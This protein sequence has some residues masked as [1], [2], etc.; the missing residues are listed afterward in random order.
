M[1]RDTSTSLHRYSTIKTFFWHAFFGNCILLLL[2]LLLSG[3]ITG[4]Y[5]YRQ[6]Q[7]DLMS[8]NYNMLYQLQQT[9][10]TML[11]TMDNVS[12]Y[13]SSNKDITTKLKRA[14]TQPTLTLSSINDAQNAGNYLRNLIYTN[15]YIDNI[16]IYYNNNN[17]R[18]LSSTAGL[19]VPESSLPDHDWIA[20][21]KECSDRFWFE[22]KTL[23]ADSSVSSYQVIRYYKKLYS[24]LN[25]ESS[26][27]VIVVNCSIP[28][29]QDYVDSLTIS[30]HQE[31]WLVSNNNMVLFKN[32]NLFQNLAPEDILRSTSSDSFSYFIRDIDGVKCFVSV[33]PSERAEG[34]RTVSIV[35]CSDLTEST[36]NVVFIYAGVMLLSIVFAVFLSLW[37]ANNEISK[38]NRI[39]NIFTDPEHSEKQLKSTR[40][41]VYDPY[42]Y[43]SSNI[44]QLF[45]Q[46]NYL[47][48]R[49][50]EQKYRMKTLELTALQQQIN[51]HFL[52]NTLNIL[53]WKSISMTGGQNEL[54]SM[55][56]DLSYIMR[57]CLADP[58]KPVLIRDNLEYLQCYLR[59]QKVRFQNRFTVDFDIDDESLSQPSLR[60]SLQPLVENAL[61]HGLKQKDG[62][63]MIQ[64]RIHYRKTY[65]YISVF[66]DGV[67]IPRKKLTEIRQQLTEAQ[68]DSVNDY[69]PHIGLFN[70]NR[71]LILSYG[72]SAAI[73]IASREGRGTLVFFRYPVSAT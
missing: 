29:I 54:S 63:G 16:Y 20:E 3:I 31:I 66:D 4:C 69:N 8:S 24:V 23:N 19:M 43:I 39:L 68:N 45:I 26:I 36:K 49:E 21:S 59:I 44:I 12:V 53:Y 37:R 14:Y 58:T 2:P 47:K 33:L 56:R 17:Q 35:P 60:L 52:H 51:P 28:A 18:V 55:I 13:L 5:L 10:D 38:L 9:F 67:G 61:S 15:K 30:E 22:V 40:S 57:Y 25:T 27:G 48:T 41:K 46:Q 32:R 50:S 62:T 73:H 11:S 64:V 72:K 1:N 34:L 71:R 70:V 65:I 7:S 42:E 6:V